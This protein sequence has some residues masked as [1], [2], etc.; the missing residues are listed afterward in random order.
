MKWEIT[1][2]R[3]YITLQDSQLKLNSNL[4]TKQDYSYGMI[5]MKNKY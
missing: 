2:F 4:V 1:K 5:T 3:P